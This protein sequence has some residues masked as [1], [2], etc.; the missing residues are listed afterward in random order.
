MSKTTTI[1]KITETHYKISDISPE[2]GIVFDFTKFKNTRLTYELRFGDKEKTCLNCDKP[3]QDGDRMYMVITD[4][5]NF[6]VCKDCVA[7]LRRKMGVK[8]FCKPE[9]QHLN[10]NEKVPYFA[11]VED[12]VNSL[13]YDVPYNGKP[14]GY[15]YHNPLRNPPLYGEKPEVVYER[16]FNETHYY[17]LTDKELT[18]LR[19]TIQY[20]C[21]YLDDFYDKVTEFLQKQGF[22]RYM[23][24]GKRGGL[25]H[26]YFKRNNISLYVCNQEQVQD[27]RPNTFT[28]EIS[29]L[30]TNPKTGKKRRVQRKSFAHIPMPD[31]FGE[32]TKESFENYIK[33]YITEQKIS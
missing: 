20:L 32:L 24:Q 31:D 15:V 25:I 28:V 27:F 22:T 26:S 2:D 23:K 29:E 33:E 6:F 4:K 21:V 13:P 16:L 14:D 19:T 11:T 12:W 3:F 10:I 9:N 1:T 17:G 30:V 8:D 5:G 7:K 18:E